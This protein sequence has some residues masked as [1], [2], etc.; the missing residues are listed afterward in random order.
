MDEE[1]VTTKPMTLEDKLEMLL[2]Y[3]VKAIKLKRKRNWLSGDI[4]KKYESKDVKSIG[5]WLRVKQKIEELEATREQVS[6]DLLYSKQLILNMIDELGKDIPEDISITYKDYRI[7]FKDV[8]DSNHTL[9]F[10]NGS[11]SDLLKLGA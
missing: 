10:V 3:V 1:V 5:Y 2:E 8:S 7:M 9:L 11:K 4:A 6:N